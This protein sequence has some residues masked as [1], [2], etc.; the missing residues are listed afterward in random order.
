MNFFLAVLVSSA[1]AGL[2]WYKKAL[3]LSGIVTA[4]FLC[5][6]IS[7]FGGWS[8]FS[9]LAVTFILVVA[10]DKFAGK[11]ADPNG[12]RQKSGARDACRVL[13]NV[14]FPA[15]AML[16]YGIS[17]KE[18][19]LFVYSVVIA[20]SL[21]DS[22]ASKFGPLTNGRTV[23]ICTF[24]ETSPGLSGGIS[25]YGSL[26]ALVGALIIG[27]MSAVFQL[28]ICRY[29]IFAALLGF[30]GCLFDSLLGSA[31]Q[32]KYI[33]PVCGTVS[34]RSMHCGVKATVCKGLKPINNDAV[35]LCSNAFV[36]AV[37]IIAGL[38]IN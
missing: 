18:L 9:I 19:Y 23:D 37:G 25:L 8:A 13:C 34:E 4:W 26:T 17:R 29:A 24:R 12:V 36:F 7:F 3:T 11:K 27:A 28:Q 35:N 33:C 30:I 21:S 32:V 10:A 16:L 5:I 20:E 38:W 1:L 31:A 22:L 14:T 6:V 2:A 15:L